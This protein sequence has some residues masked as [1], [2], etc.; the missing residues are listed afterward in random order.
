M[1]RAAC[2]VCGGVYEPSNLPGL[3]T[4]RGCRCVTANIAIS[5]AELD[6]LYSANYFAGE[7]YHDYIAERRIIEKNFRTRLKTL[8]ACVPHAALTPLEA[9]RSNAGRAAC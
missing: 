1:K 8:L 7:E 3:L 6:A 9:C 4:C 5:S 2:L